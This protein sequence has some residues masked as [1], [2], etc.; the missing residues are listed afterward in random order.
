MNYDFVFSG[1]EEQKYLEKKEKEKVEKLYNEIYD[2]FN[3]CE[4]YGLT[5]REGQLNMALSVYDAI[6]SKKSL[7]IE[8]GVGIGKSYAYIIPLLFYYRLMKKSFIISTSTI[9]LQEQLEKDLKKISTDLNI[10][11]DIVVAKGMNNFI[12]KR[13]LESFLKSNHEKYKGIFKKDNQDRKDYLN[14]ED[15]VW[16]QINVD[17][18]SYEKCENCQKCEFYNRRMQMKNANGA[19]ICNHDLLI[20][21]LK[22]N[23]KNLFQKV[24]YIVCDEAHNIENKVRASYTKEFKIKKVM[25]PLKRTIDI[26]RV[27]GRKNYSENS[28]EKNIKSLNDLIDNNVNEYINKLKEDNIDILDCNGIELSF[29]KNITDLSKKIVDDI[30]DIYDSLQLLDLPYDDLIDLLDEYIYVFSILSEGKKSN[31]IFWIERRNKINYIY[32][33]PKNIAQLS[34]RLFFKTNNDENKKTF[35][36]TS[37]TLST[38]KDNYD[39]FINNLG[40][41]MESI[42]EENLIIEN[43]EESPYDYDNNTLLYCCSDI[44][45]PKN[46]NL[47]LKQL[48]KKIKELILLTDGKTLV[49]FTSKS[50]MNYVYKQI[51]NKINDIN[52]YIQNDGSS[53]DI[54]KQKFKE[55]INSVLFSTGIFWEGIDI[56]G[57]SLSNLIIARLP[58]PIVD[59]VIE[60]KKNIYGFNKV[61][62]P[63]MLIKLKQGIG[64]LI[65]NENDKGIVCILDSRIK[66]YEKIVKKTIPIKNFTYNIDILKDFV[67]KI[68]L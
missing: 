55:D 61:Y 30:S 60:Y 23:N 65:R 56:P 29:N 22:N 18:C 32:Y 37:A 11:L 51:G 28:I 58:F 67:K 68:S 20:Y 49:L 38:E 2:Y 44:E 40:S 36:F 6:E 41:N 33:A 39:Y 26:L 4:S 50:D 27:F 14:V 35:I 21:D 9:A 52:I 53:Q 15:K 24:D 47:Y 17:N 25:E 45:N 34:N 3:D 46:K 64:R 19:I 16:N 8:G 7:V 48:V 5:K 66:A 1:E 63:E 13:R 59:P 62:I 31:Y 12:C 57:K 43:S 42:E 10:P 54:I